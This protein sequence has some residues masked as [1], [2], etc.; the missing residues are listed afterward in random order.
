[1]LRFIVRLFKWNVD[2]PPRMLGRWGYNWEKKL[3]HQKYYD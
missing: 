1:M 2:P 3:Q